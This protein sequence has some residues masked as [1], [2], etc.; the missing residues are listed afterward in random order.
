VKHFILACTYVNAMY[1]PFAL[2][3][4][5]S[6]EALPRDC[7]VDFQVGRKFV[8]SS[9]SQGVCLWCVFSF[10]YVINFG[11]SNMWEIVDV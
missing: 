7:S 2:H 1:F 6:E 11:D 9:P 8:E 10:D 4:Q 3:L 5:Y